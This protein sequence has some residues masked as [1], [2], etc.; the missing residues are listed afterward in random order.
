M[1]A[2]LNKKIAMLIV[3]GLS[4][5]SKMPCFGFSIP[6]E[7]CNVGSKLRKIKGSICS[8]CYA[9]RGRYCFDNVQGALNHRYEAFLNAPRFVEAMVY[10]LNNHEHS[11]FFRWFDSGDIP[12]MDCLNKIVEIAKQTPGIQHW[13]PTKEYSLITEWV[14]LNGSFPANLTVRLSAYMMEGKPPTALAKR[15]GVFTSSASRIG[16]TCPAP[17]QGGK[18]ADCRACWDKNTS[19]VT[20]KRH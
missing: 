16:F 1:T 18:C 2:T 13:L 5:P 10:L 11:G 12:N 20:Y 6:A 7:K 3:G 17:K 14:K 19:N 8:T 9:C 15:L 4:E